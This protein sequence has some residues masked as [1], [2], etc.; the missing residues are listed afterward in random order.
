MLYYTQTVYLA[1]LTGVHAIVE[2]RGL[3]P[4]DFTLY[5]DP[6]PCAVFFAKTQLF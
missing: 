2:A 1:T 5:T 4:T 3:V 6:R